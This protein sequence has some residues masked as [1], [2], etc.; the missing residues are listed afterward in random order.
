MPIELKMPALSPTMEEG[1]LAKWL[2]KEGDKVAS[3]AVMAEIETDK[4]PLGFEAVGGG[5]LRAFAD[6]GGGHARQV[7]GQGG[8]QGRLRRG[9]GG[10]RDRQGPPGVRGCRRRR[11][12]HFRRP[13]R[14]AR[15]PS[16]WSGRAT[17]SPPA[18]SWR[19]S[20]PTRPPWSSR[21][22]TKAF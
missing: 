2:V 16:G 18:R 15:S 3:G 6:H 1:T 21:L 7:A 12:P 9:H 11:S 5:G 8:R 20:R 22:S 13:W 17:R 10:D 19:R 4:A 14:R